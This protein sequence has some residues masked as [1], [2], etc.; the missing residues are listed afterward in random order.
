MIILLFGVLQ[1]I[2]NVHGFT[3][4]IFANYG[5]PVS[6]KV[7]E[8]YGYFPR[9]LAQDLKQQV[10]EMF[11][12]GYDNY[13]QHAWPKDE[14]NPID[15]VGRG[16]DWDNP[17]DQLGSLIFRNLCMCLSCRHYCSNKTIV[18]QP[19]KINTH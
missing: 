6:G 7:L 17:Y 14:L 4:G 3:S 1:S 10:K 9:H 8:D 2:A 11:Y 13:M 16:P 12:F 19:S 5:I 18:F 15:C